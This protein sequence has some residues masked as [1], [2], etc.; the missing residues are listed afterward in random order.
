MSVHVSRLFSSAAVIAVAV[1]IKPAVATEATFPP[2]HP[3]A[4]DSPWPLGFNGPY[5]QQ[6]SPSPGP[7]PGDEI[8]IDFVGRDAAAPLP[9]GLTYSAPYREGVYVTYGTNSR[10][11]YKIVRTKTTLEKA[12][13]LVADIYRLGRGLQFTSGYWLPDGRTGAYFLIA[14]RLVHFVD[15][16]AGNPRSSM[17][18]AASLSIESAF[19]DRDGRARRLVKSDFALGLQRLYS[20]AIVFTTERGSL[21]AVDS[22]LTVASLTCI[23]LLGDRSEEGE[24]VRNAIA[25]EPGPK[26]TDDIYLTT[27]RAVIKIR[28]EPN[29]RRFSE[30]WREPVADSGSTPTLMGVGP[31]ED[32]LLLVTTFPEPGSDTPY[33]LVAVWRDD[34]PPA[35]GSRVADTFPLTFGLDESA[36][37]SV[38]PTQNSVAVRGRRAVIPNFNGIFTYAEPVPPSAFGVEAV[39]WNPQTSQ[40]ERA[41]LNPDVYIPNSMVAISDPPSGRGL[42]YMIG[43]DD[44]RTTDRPTN[45]RLRLR[46]PS[47]D[48]AP[49][50]TLVALDLETGV[51]AAEWPIGRGPQWNVY[52]S[53][54]Q[55]GPDSEILT[56]GA[57]GVYRLRV[58]DGDESRN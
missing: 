17:A 16:V 25:A 10:E 37:R 27:S 22:A 35:S 39:D 58:T 9:S 32:R 4:A 30:I 12:D 57:R 6:S 44:F 50:W 34:A 54:V 38:K 49:L 2:P 31:D 33:E 51:L 48:E 7:Q 19:L 11:I 42:A 55:I 29:T 23:D 46:Q 1:F 41:W 21:C 8:A 43:L 14:D 28:F 15:A 47:G 45:R 5:A 52:G 26:G 56:S 40:L 18:E 24:G 53:G 13:F 3:F 36:A 20:G